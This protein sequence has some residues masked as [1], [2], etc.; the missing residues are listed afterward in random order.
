MRNARP[1]FIQEDVWLSNVFG[2]PVFRIALP[3]AE[4][5][6]NDQASILATEVARHSCHQERATYY[7]KLDV[8]LVNVGKQLIAAGFYVV[9][10]QV[11]LALDTVRLSPTNSPVTRSSFT[12]REVTPDMR[13][14]VCEIARSCFRFSRFHQDPSVNPETADQIKRAWVQSYLDGNRGER[15]FIAAKEEHPV[16]FLAVLATNAEGKEARVIDL[17]GVARSHQ[18]QGVGKALVNFFID[19]YRDCCDILKVGTQV[20]NVPSLRLYQSC[21]FAVANSSY[22]LHKHVGIKSKESI[23]VDAH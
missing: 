16:G 14:A 17:I 6:S 2:Y 10:V 21:G 7:A 4:R 22:V 11:T 23:T 18:R 5:L 12:I 1:V 8:T 15:L 19:H 13:A 3:A 9:D 20:A